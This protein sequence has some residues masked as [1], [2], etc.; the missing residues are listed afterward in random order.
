M[1]SYCTQYMEAYRSPHE[2]PTGLSVPMVQMKNENKK[3]R[4]QNKDLTNEVET[5]KKD[6]YM[7]NEKLSVIKH[8]VRKRPRPLDLSKIN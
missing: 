5:L 8:V 6:L 2:S 7:L 4:E 1:T 3:L